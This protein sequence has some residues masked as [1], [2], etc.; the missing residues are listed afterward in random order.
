MK[1]ITL[2]FVFCTTISMIA[3]S[4]KGNNAVNIG[5]DVYLGLKSFGDAYKAGLGGHVKGMYGVGTAGHATLTVGYASFKGKKT[6]TYDYSKQKFSLIPIL[7]GYRHQFT[8]LFVEPQ[9]GM[10]SSSLKYDG[11]KLFSQTKFMYAIGLGYLLQDFE[12]NLSFQNVGEAGEIAL[13]AGL[14]YNIPLAKK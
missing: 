11:E 2:S 9:L 4:Q 8:S 5:P 6:D 13:R 1:R 10:G 14:A 7:L 12:I 3:F